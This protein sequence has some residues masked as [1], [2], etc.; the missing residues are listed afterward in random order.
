MRV[1]NSSEWAHDHCMATPG[2]HSLSVQ[3]LVQPTDSFINRTQCQL[4]SVR[5]FHGT[6]R[7]D[8]EETAQHDTLENNNGPKLTRPVLSGW[9]QVCAQVKKQAELSYSSSR[10]RFVGIAKC[11]V[12]LTT[13]I[14]V[15][16]HMAKK[17]ERHSQ[18]G[19][20]CFPRNHPNKGKLPT[21]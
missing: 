7:K 20:L 16:G 4:Q 15:V 17:R 13:Q 2:Q 1:D 6:G 21:R 19:Q 10:C 5:S 8:Q 18:S 14:D 3:R 12:G 11:P 9:P